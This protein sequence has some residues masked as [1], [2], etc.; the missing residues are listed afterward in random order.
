MQTIP[1][2]NDGSVISFLDFELKR[3]KTLNPQYSLRSFAN[4]LNISPASLSQVLSGRRKLAGIVK[5]KIVEKL[6]IDKKLSASENLSYEL[7]DYTFHSQW[8]Y[9]AILELVKFSD[10][11][12]S[13]K[14]ISQKLNISKLEAKKAI[15]SLKKRNLLI[16]NK[17]GNWID[18]STGHTSHITSQGTSE[19]RKNYQSELLRLSMESLVNDDIEQRDHT[20]MMVSIKKDKIPLAKELIKEFRRKFAKLIDSKENPDHIYQLAL[21]FFPITKEIKK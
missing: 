21:S 3:R 2:P 12:T 14:W 9:D 15:A 11:K 16:K 10:F 18:N 13:S 4:Y 17:S 6:E 19:A 1:T 8:Q 7:L 5:N 20:S